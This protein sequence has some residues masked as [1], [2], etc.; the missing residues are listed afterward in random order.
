MIDFKSY[1][2]VKEISNLKFGIFLL[3]ITI[4]VNF[5]F[6]ITD[7]FFL[8]L[9]WILSFLL[10]VI[11]FFFPI[12][13]YWPKRIWVEFGNFLGKFISFI[14]LLIIFYFIFTPVGIFLKLF[15]FDLMNLNNKSNLS[16]YWEE[17]N[18]VNSSMKDQF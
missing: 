17:Y 2:K 9:L 8:I 7:G 1:Y 18:K 16:S 3:S 14:I 5:Y 11:S 15:K 6:F 13:L 12:Y 4:L 10:L